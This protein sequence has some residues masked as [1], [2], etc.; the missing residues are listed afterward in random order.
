VNMG[1]YR[2]CRGHAGTP[3]SAVD[4][5]VSCHARVDADVT[6]VKEPG[7]GRASADGIPRTNQT[8]DQSRCET[9]MVRCDKDVTRAN[10]SR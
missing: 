1:S 3:L 4:T 9:S 8:R 2:Q 5:L 10:R 7:R 6:D